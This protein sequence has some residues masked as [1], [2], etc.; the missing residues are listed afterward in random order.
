[1]SGRLLLRWGVYPLETNE[2]SSVD[3]LFDIGARLTRDL[4][5]ARPGGLIVITGGI[6][7]GEPGST[8]L[9]KVQSVD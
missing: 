9:L 6:P 4:G 5:L 8:N 7:L 3:E 2:L 1:V